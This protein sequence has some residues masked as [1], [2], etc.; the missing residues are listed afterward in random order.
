MS[1][2]DPTTKLRTS[3]FGRFVQLNG[4][5]GGPA[6]GVALARRVLKHGVFEAK[7]PGIVFMYRINFGLNSILATLGAEANWL[8]VMAEIDDRQPQCLPIRLKGEH[9]CKSKTPA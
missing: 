8:V 3:R 4:L 1:E 9:R 6:G 5:A 2:P 7:Q